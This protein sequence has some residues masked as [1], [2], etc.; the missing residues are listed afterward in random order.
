M[1]VVSPN[2]TVTFTIQPDQEVAITAVS[3]DAVITLG[4]QP[5]G[6]VVFDL[7]GRT[8]KNAV[9]VPKG[10]IGTVTIRTGLAPLSYELT[11]SSFLTVESN[12]LTGG[13]G[14]TGTIVDMDETPDDTNTATAMV[15]APH[16][17]PAQMRCT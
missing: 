13:M 17:S 16:S 12:L 15:Q 9:V 10:R 4:A 8:F 3:S 7:A 2:S 1:P 11:R 5:G 14:F 6:D